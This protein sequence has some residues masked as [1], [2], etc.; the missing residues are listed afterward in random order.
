MSHLFIQ[1]SDPG[2]FNPSSVSVQ[3]QMRA[4]LRGAIFQQSAQRFDNAALLAATVAFKQCIHSPGRLR[5]RRIQSKLRTP[6][7]R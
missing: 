7:V 4:H 6:L 3:E 2:L 1:G 5:Q